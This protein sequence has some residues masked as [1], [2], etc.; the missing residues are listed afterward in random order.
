MRKVPNKANPT[1][2]SSP[3]SIPKTAVAANV[4]ALVTGTAKEMGVSL[5]IA[6]KV[7]EAV[8]FTINGKEYCQVSKRL[9]QFLSVLMTGFWGVFGWGVDLIFLSQ[10]MA[11]LRI[12]A[13]VAPQTRPTATIFSTS[14]PIAVLLVVIVTMPASVPDLRVALGPG[15]RLRGLN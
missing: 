5:R 12:R 14:L 9:S 10:M 13:L 1:W 6:K 4:V 15:A 3:R 7:A 11:P 2:V 8:R